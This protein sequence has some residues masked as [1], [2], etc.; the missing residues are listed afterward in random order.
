LLIVSGAVVAFGFPALEPALLYDRTAVLHG[1][2]WRLWTGHWVHFGASHLLWN[3]LVLVPAGVWAEWL[4]PKSFRLLSILAPGAIGAVLLA[5]DPALERYG[6]LSGLAAAVLAFLAFTELTASPDGRWFWRG[7]LM[8]L[9]IKI[10]AEF[11]ADQSLFARFEDPGVRAVPLAHL[12]GAVTAAAVH[13]A[14]R[15]RQI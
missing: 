1:E 3:L 4:A 7:V 11:L 2:F 15:R 12:A 13:F 9:V 6:G 5:F 8:L 10:V 14:G